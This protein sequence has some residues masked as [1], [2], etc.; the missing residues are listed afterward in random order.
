M[1]AVGLVH[2]ALLLADMSPSSSSFFIIIWPRS[3]S[4][5]DICPDL[6]PLQQVAQLAQ[7]LLGLV[8]RAVLRHVLEVLHHA[9]EV[10][11]GKLLVLLVETLGRVLVLGVLRQLLDVLAQ[12]V[13]QLLHQAVDLGVGRALLQRLGELVLR[14]AQRPLRV[15]QVAVLD[16]QREL[17]QAVGHALQARARAVALQP[18]QGVRRPR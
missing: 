4:F 11:L 5:F 15:R 3:A 7:H 16:A 8:A 9:L 13:A 10:L 2:Q 6:Q 1:L 12:R 17:P 18:V 14:V